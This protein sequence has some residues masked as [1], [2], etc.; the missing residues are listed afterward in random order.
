MEDRLYFRYWDGHNKK[1]LGPWAIIEIAQ[2]MDAMTTETD[3]TGGWLAFTVMQCTGLKDK[4][5]KDIYEGDI[6]H[7]EGSGLYNSMA[8]VEWVVDDEETCG[9]VITDADGQRVWN[10][11]L[12]G[13]EIVGNIHAN[14]ELLEAH[15]K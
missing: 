9:F 15:D 14:P 7:V 5:G 4:N 2:A 8:V 6:L 3:K 13:W 10:V 1:M 11:A 12:D